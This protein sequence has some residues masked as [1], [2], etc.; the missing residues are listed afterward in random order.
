[1]LFWRLSGPW[2]GSDTSKVTV[3]FHERASTPIYTP[4]THLLR[5]DQEELLIDDSNDRFVTG[6]YDTE[7]RKLLSWACGP[8]GD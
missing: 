5:A 2:L 8:N 1:M 6:T 7:T 3:H 4:G